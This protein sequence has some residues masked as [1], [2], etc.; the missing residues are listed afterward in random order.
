MSMRSLCIAIAAVV[1]VRAFGQEEPPKGAKEIFHD[2][3]SRSLTVANEMPRDP[4]VRRVTRSHS[5][6]VRRVLGISYWIE[7]VGPSHAAGAQ[8]TND[9]TFRS[10]ERIRLHFRSAVTGHIELVLLGSS[11]AS[12]L[13]YPDRVKGLDEN[14]VHPEG[15]R[16]LPSERHWFTFDQHPGTERL[17]VLFARTQGEL[18]RTFDV[19]PK[20]NAEE[21]DALLRYLDRRKGSKDLII[22]SE[23]EKADEVGVYGVSI[24]GQPVML[25]VTLRHE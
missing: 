17:L 4:D 11:G 8:V 16:I 15:E 9:R 13:L 14:V 25:D 22:E 19:H 1:C 20:M 6:G 7:L 10:G 5:D 12:T 23:T 2:E 3:L 18:D 24:S 21:T